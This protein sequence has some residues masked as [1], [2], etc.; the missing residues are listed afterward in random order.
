[1]KI[2]VITMIAY[3]F[4][5]STLVTEDNIPDSKCNVINFSEHINCEHDPKVIRVNELIKIIENKKKY[6][7]ELRAER[8]KKSNKLFRQEFIDEINQKLKE[9]QPFIDE[10]A[11]IKK[12][13]TKN[14]LCGERYYKFYKGYKGVIPT[15]LQN[16]LDARKNTRKQMKNSICK[17]ENCKDIA[18]YG[19]DKPIFCKLHKEKEHNKLIQD[20]KVNDIKLLNNV[21]EKRQLAYKVSAN[22]MYGSWGVQRGY[23]PFMAGAIATTYMGRTNIEIVAKTIQEKYGGKLVYGD[24]VRD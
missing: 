13:I 6:I 19:I 21:L 20:D 7:K 9:V 12:T 8:D 18:Q 22:S 14:I 2:K 3:N 1:M 11:K 4:D 10:R 15:I 16:L 23:L 24:K 17:D 5:Y